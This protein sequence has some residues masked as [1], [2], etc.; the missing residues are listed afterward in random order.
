MSLDRSEL[1]FQSLFLYIKEGISKDFCIEVQNEPLQVESR[2]D[3]DGQ[4]RSDVYRVNQDLGAYGAIPVSKGR[5]WFS[6]ETVSGS[7]CKIYDPDSGEFI[8]TYSTPYEGVPLSIP[9]QREENLITVY[10]QSG[11]PM[12]RDH[13][14]IDYEKGRIRWPAATTPSGSLGNVPTTIDYT[15]HGVSVLEAF[16]TDGD[17]PPLPV[18]A[19]YPV[20]G[21]L[22]GFQIGPGVKSRQQYV[23]DVFAESEAQKRKILNQL[24]KILY[25]KHAPVI[26]FNRSG[27]PLTQYGAVNPE[28]IQDLEYNGE[29]YRSYLTLNPGNGCN[30]YFVNTEVSYNTSPR[31]SMS[32]LVRHSGRIEFNT[33]TFTD[34]DPSLV[35]KF[36]AMN[37]PIGGLDSLTLKGY[38]E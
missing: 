34:R 30:L 1:E 20:T 5:G 18:V 14:R 16:P 35:G 3:L 15:F 38:S 8:S 24:K 37:P 11:T 33:E 7:S 13:Y 23:I 12:P 17:V 26:D 28:F 32:D 36:S 25:N 22:M 27:M 10:D 9:T 2:K 31:L 29:T 19:V 21:D 4:I 6:F